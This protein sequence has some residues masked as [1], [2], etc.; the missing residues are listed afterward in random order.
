MG[1]K[2]LE[3]KTKVGRYF[4]YFE[5][6]ILANKCISESLRQRVMYYLN[7]SSSVLSDIKIRGE[8]E[9]L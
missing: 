8:A 7:M 6:L 2:E 4:K 9:Y 3:L 5:F 1:F